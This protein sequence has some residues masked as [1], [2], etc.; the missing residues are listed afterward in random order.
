MNESRNLRDT[1]YVKLEIGQRRERF[2]I[3]TL[4]RDFQRD[5]VVQVNNVNNV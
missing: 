2:C 3:F 4:Q 1:M 5:V